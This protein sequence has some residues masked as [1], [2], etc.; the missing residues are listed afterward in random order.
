M[1]RSRFLRLE[2]KVHSWLPLREEHLRRYEPCLFERVNDS[3]DEFFVLEYAHEKRPSLP[4]A[5]RTHSDH[6]FEGRMSKR[7]VLPDQAGDQD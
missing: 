3:S 6:E 4:F 5:L 2:E 1:R 7:P